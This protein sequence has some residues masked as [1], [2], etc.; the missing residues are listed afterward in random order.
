MDKLTLTICIPSYN[1]LGHARRCVA[2]LLAQAKDRPVCIV[3]LDN[4]SNQNY[5]EAFADDST[6]RHAMDKGLLSVR[7]NPCNIGMSANFL[8]AFEIAQSRWLWLVSDDD[9]IRSD[10]I[11]EV[12]AAIHSHEAEA[13]FI[14]FSS[15]RSRPEQELVRLRTLE[16][17]VDFNSMS[18][19]AFNGFLFI[20]NGIYR[21]SDFRP[22]LS[23]GYQYANTYIPHF[24]ML[25]AYMAHGNCCVIAR[26]GIVDYVV[27][28]VGYSYGMLAGLGVGAPKHFLV[29]LSPD[30][31]RKFLRLFFP[32][33]DFKVIIDLFYQCKRDATP[34]VCGHLVDCYL[35]YVSVARTIP[36]MLALRSFG[37][38]ARFPTA[39]EWLVAIAE[40]GSGMIRKH[41]KE[42]RM[43]YSQ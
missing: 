26:E 14:K 40:R 10:A 12:L 23:I 27:P 17:F 2:S 36:K 21:L 1:R 43:R 30:Y 32:H 39:F 24:M 16:E 33:N 41:V 28:E 6:F 37:N 9:D 3:V 5:I 42:I 35:N 19:H 22:L 7:R 18:V 31:Y 38:L 4:A 34:Y 11:A 20:S 15:P 13:G 8:R 29:K 25:T